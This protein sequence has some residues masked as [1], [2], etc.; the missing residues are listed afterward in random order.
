MRRGLSLLGAAVAAL[1]LAGPGAVADPE[2]QTAASGGNLS[3][4]VSADDVALGQEVHL[5]GRMTRAGTG[6]SGMRVA[7]QADPY[8]F[9]AWRTLTRT[10][11]GEHGRFH[12]L[13]RPHRNTRYRA[14]ADTSPL[15]TTSPLT[16]FADLPG[17]VRS[18]RVSGERAIVRVFLLVPSYAR[19]PGRRVHVYVFRPDRPRGSRV[20]SVL[21]Q[22]TSA[23]RWSGAVHFKAGGVTRR[24]YAVMCIRERTQ[25]GWGR[26]R[27]IDRVCGRHRI[28]KPQL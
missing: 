13:H 2:A 19:L 20:G 11:T 21:L 7:I 9:G 10:R 23:H 3:F 5:Q 27:R 17:G 18:F 26:L 1:A 12:F 6:W 4:A 22:R 28:R 16:V 15:T 14:V 8:P 24:S 25:D